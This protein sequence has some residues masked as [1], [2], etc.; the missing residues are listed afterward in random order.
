M[1]DWLPESTSVSAKTNE[2]PCIKVG[3]S[4][5]CANDNPSLKIDNPRLILLENIRQSCIYLNSELD[6]YWQY[7]INFSQTCGDINNLIFTEDCSLEVLNYTSKIDKCIFDVVN[8]KV[9]VSQNPVADDYNLYKKYNVNR[10]PDLIINDIKYRGTWHSKYIFHSICS[11]FIDNS[12]I[13]NEPVDLSA[14]DGGL[15]VGSIIFIIFIVLIAMV[16]LLICYRRIVNKSLEASLNEKIQTQT[17]FSLGQYH[18]FKD[19]NTGRKSVDVAK[20]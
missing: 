2:A 8:N 11:G 14:M 6:D 4:H 12:T 19:E 13:C 16:I 3:N 18:V 17:I 15:N 5:Y 10:V 7:M 20:L 1:Y 9:P